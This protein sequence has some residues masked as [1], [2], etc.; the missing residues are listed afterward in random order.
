MVFWLEGGVA[1]MIE[2]IERGE[3]LNTLYTPFS[4]MNKKCKQCG[5]VIK[6]GM[7]YRNRIIN[8]RK[9]SYYEPDLRPRIFCSRQCSGKYIRKQHLLQLNKKYCKNCKK[10][11]IPCF[12]KRI[13]KRYG[14]IYVNMQ[15]CS[16]PSKFCSN[17]CSGIWHRGRSKDGVHIIKIKKVTTKNNLS[18]KK[19]VN[20]EVKF[21]RLYRNIKL[22]KCIFCN[23][24][25]NFTCG[26]KRYVTRMFCSNKCRGKHKHKNNVK[27]NTKE[28]GYCGKLFYRVT[29]KIF[30]SVQCV[31]KW[32]IGRHKNGEKVKIKKCENC[33]NNIHYLIHKI[34]G[35]A[36][37]YKNRRFCSKKCCDLAKIG[38]YAGKNHPNYV[39]G[40]SNKPYTLDFSNR[41]KQNIFSRDNKKCVICKKEVVSGFCHHIHYDKSDSRL[42]TLVCLCHSHH[43]MTN[44][45]RDYWFAYFCKYLSQ[46]PEEVL[47]C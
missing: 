29:P 23:K 37:S 16:I 6:T 46:E 13:R 41:L 12:F 34:D 11:I 45:N 44:F 14:H 40:E 20:K 47:V 3:A 9:Y 5:K 15:M 42:N 30:C 17:K 4:S 31:G 36:D 27:K 35:Y 21:K 24:N 22:R 2:A 1:E 28:C 19:T 25:I 32:R 8:R 10:E 7:W 26:Y 38:L 39:N 33:G 43:S 18:V